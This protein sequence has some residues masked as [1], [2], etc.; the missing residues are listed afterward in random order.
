MSPG[1]DGPPSSDATGLPASEVPSPGEVAVGLPGASLP[2]IATAD[3]AAG[4][5]T[6]GSVSEAPWIIPIVVTLLVLA[7]G[8]FIMFRKPGAIG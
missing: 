7:I 4:Q 6:G 2:P 8:G 3:D 1:A 5:P